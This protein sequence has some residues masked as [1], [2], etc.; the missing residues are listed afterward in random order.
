MRAGT[1]TRAAPILSARGIVNRFGRQQ[2]HDHVGL[3]I[4]SG[5]IVGIAGGSGSG[6]SVLL[7]TLAGLHR[8]DAGEVLVEGKPVADLGQAEKASLIGVLFQHGALFSSL[9]VA[10]NIMLPMREHTGLAPH[11]RETIAAMK[12]ALAG[13]PATDGP[14][15]PSQL[16]GGMIKRAA[17]A[18]ALALDP[19]ILFLDE[20][21]SD[22]DPLTAT[23]ID[24]LIRELNRGLGIT[25]VVVTH[26]LTTLFSV[27]DRLA[28]LVDGH[29]H[30]GTLAALMRSREPWIRDFLHG[31]RA[32][33]AAH[34]RR[35]NNGNG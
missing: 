20:P 24:T 31:P 3:E 35:A 25:V 28:V 12:L 8:P 18:R 14:K 26:D 11:D 32:R 9:S 1:R 7:K 16:S 27:C 22:L 21:T 30:T 29:L 23:G 15:L 19:R 13:L 5:E 34:A 2:V 6:K 4:K 10:D 17:L 33:G